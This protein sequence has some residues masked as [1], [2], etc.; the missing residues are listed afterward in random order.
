M[1]IFTYDQCIKMLYEMSVPDHVIRHSIVVEKV[2]SFLTRALLNGG[3]ILDENLVK[4]AALLHDITKVISIES[5]E[6]HDVTGA[7]LL[8]KLGYPDIARIVSQHI[9][10]N[11]FDV[12][13]P[14]SEAEIVFYSDKRVKHDQIVSID[15]RYGDSIL[16]VKH[17]KHELEK[18]NSRIQ[19]VK[20]LENKICRIIS[21]DPLDIARDISYA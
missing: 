7:I 6:R 20:E 5:D 13:G 1:R 21:V 8:E 19:M 11:S 15:E 12:T 16:K 2:A 9:S 17:D 4:S 10:L 18:L 14:V 3:A